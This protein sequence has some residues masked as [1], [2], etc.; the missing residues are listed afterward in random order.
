MTYWTRRANDR[1]KTPITFPNLFVCKAKS[2]DKLGLRQGYLGDLLKE[3]LI[4]WEN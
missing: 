4:S 2:E 1:L 3:E